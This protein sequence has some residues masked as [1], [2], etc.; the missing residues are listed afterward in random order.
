MVEK[1]HTGLLHRLLNVAP[2]QEI[3]QETLR[4]GTRSNDETTR[5]LST[6]AHNIHLR[7][8]AKKAAA[9]SSGGKA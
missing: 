9:D 7:E 2:D 8:V 6:L 1:A 5:R 3:P 4:E